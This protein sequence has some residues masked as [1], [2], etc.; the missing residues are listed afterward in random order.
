LG[1]AQRDK[2]DAYRFIEAHAP[3]NTTYERAAAILV[4]GKERAAVLEAKIAARLDK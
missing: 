2:K 3:R 4:A 1:T